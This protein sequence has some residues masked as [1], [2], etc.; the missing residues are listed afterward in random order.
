VGTERTERELGR[1][2]ITFGGLSPFKTEKEKKTKPERWLT[3]MSADI[4]RKGAIFNANCKRLK[5][6]TE[7][8]L[9]CSN[10][11]LLMRPV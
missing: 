9:F 4:W 7:H 2:I 10:N 3:K 1:L 6:M 11:Y 8:L 5:L